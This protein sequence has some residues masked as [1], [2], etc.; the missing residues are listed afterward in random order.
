VGRTFHGYQTLDHLELALNS[1]ADLVA[2]HQV[3]VVVVA[4]DIFDTAV[5]SGAAMEL[6][7][8]VLQRMIQSG[9]Q[10]VLTSGNHDSAARLGYLA[11]FTAAAGLHIFADPARIDRPVRIA[12]RDGGEVLF[13]GIPFLDPIMVRHLS[14]ERELNS[15]SDVMRFA[16]EQIKS[17]V[18]PE[19]RY[20]V[21]A[22]T[23]VVPRR[24]V[25]DV[26]P[27]VDEVVDARSAPR[28]FTRG[29]LD[30]VTA[31]VFDGATY[32]ALGHIHGRSSLAPHIR[33]SGAP[34]YYSF[35]EEGRKRGAWLV[36][37][38]PKGDLTVEWVDIPVPRAI[39]QINGELSDLLSAQEHAAAQDCWVK[40]I[41]TD[42]TRPVD[43]VRRL[44]QRF[45]FCAEIEYRPHNEFRDNINTYTER[46]KSLS[47]AEIAANFLAHVRNGEGPSAAEQA[48]IAELVKS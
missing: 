4:G 46:I 12:D 14:P 1:L 40:A 23:F 48:L 7:G 41:L 16:M 3:D 37:I 47:D 29:G 10:I 39:K 13:F 21:A 22:H 28:D 36:D 25:G 27:A 33:Y 34:L 31:D 15:Q 8:R 32:V 35:G 2:K 42:A 20:V 43:A 24:E 18:S 45:P 11:N 38:P 9:C 30:Y 26:S 5:P 17:A 6:L 44:Q 19:D